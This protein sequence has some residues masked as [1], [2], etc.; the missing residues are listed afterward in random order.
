MTPIEA[1][2]RAIAAEN[3]RRQFGHAPSPGWDADRQWRQHIPAARAVI[4]AIREPSEAMVNAAVLTF[5]R[6]NGGIEHAP[7][8]TWSAMI[9]SALA[10]QPEEAT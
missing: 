8:M 5:V 10:E 9:D 1:A 3:F 2:A 7:F 4:E 6:E